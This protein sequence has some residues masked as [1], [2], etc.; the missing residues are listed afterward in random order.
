MKKFMF[1]L[2]AL[3]VTV[4]MA[5]QQPQERPGKQNRFSKEDVENFKKAAQ[6]RLQSE[7]VAYLTNELELTPE[8][9]QAFWPI[10]N[11]A[12]AEQRANFE[13]LAAAKKALKAAVKE[14]K[15]DSEVKKALDAYNK[16][17]A[18]QHDVIGEYQPKF[19][20]ILGVAKT[21]KLYLAEDSF[22]TRQIH[23]LSGN[24]NGR[25][26]QGGKPGFQG[27]KGP[28]NGKGFQGKPGQ[29]FDGK[30]G[31]Q[32]KPGQNPGRQ[33]KEK[34]VQQPVDA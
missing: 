12:Q 17:K 32:G 18:S 26:P 6:E 21:A 31:S 19:E 30:P 25:G 27:G 16:A 23:R 5:A 9:A 29:K 34:P 2:A 13:E 20:K 3:C 10:Y 4:G 24:G 28:Q 8:E 15:S 7:H 22:R 11:Q 33:P 14:G 1:A